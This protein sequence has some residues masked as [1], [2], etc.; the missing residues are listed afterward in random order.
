MLDE[1]NAEHWGSPAPPTTQPKPVTIKR[2]PVAK[3]QLPPTHSHSCKPKH[4]AMYEFTFEDVHMRR[5]TLQDKCRDHLTK[6][7]RRNK[8]AWTEEEINKLKQLK[9]D[10][11]DILSI[12]EVLGRSRAAVYKRLQRSGAVDKRKKWTEARLSVVRDLLKQGYTD[13]QIGEEMGVSAGAINKVVQDY[14]LR[15]YR[16]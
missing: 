11:M 9:Q 15:R 6:P 16:R 7:A 12:C 5:G 1:R 8:D 10:G 2:R 3:P 4:N 13:A 14:H